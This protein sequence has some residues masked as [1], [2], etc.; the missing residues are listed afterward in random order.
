[1]TAPARTRGELSARVWL[2]LVSVIG[3]VLVLVAVFVLA[4]WRTQAENGRRDADLR[5]DLC[6]LLTVQTV[7]TP[8]PTGPAGDRARALI[9]RID[10]LKRTTCERGQY[11]EEQ[12]EG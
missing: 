4:M 11:G 5:R 9:P 1:V 7:P 10:A 3:G 6:A 8:I 12:G 2:L